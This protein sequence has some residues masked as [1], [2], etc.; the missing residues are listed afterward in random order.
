MRNRTFFVWEG[1][2]QYL[3][4]EGV[5]ATFDWLAEAATGGLLS[6]TYVRK[7]F[8]TGQQLYGWQSGYK[9]FVET[10]TWQFGLE[11]EACPAL[12]RNCGWRLIEDV[13]YEELAHE[14]IRPT[15]RSL[16]STQV[17]RIVYAE[18]VD[19]PNQRI[20]PPEF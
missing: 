20:V 15:G 10:G 11:P 7:S 13:A 9:R 14:Y 19:P 8:L 4:E 16:A 6:F 12:L 5:R 18:K 1:V 3:T 17:E 2:T